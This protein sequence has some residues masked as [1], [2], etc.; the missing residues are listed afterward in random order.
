MLREKFL[1]KH[2]EAIEKQQK[3]LF[4]SWQKTKI[5]SS[6][7]LSDIINH[8]M[9]NQSLGR[10]VCVE[11]GWLNK[12]GSLN[13]SAPAII[14]STFEEQKREEVDNFQTVKASTFQ[15]TR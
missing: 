11:L 4:G 15:N 14:R 7:K 2:A 12:D 5:Q 3:E 10:D 1:F 6:L 13:Q 8:A 9:N